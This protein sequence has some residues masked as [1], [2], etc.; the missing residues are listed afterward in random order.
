M[1]WGNWQDN[2]DLFDDLLRQVYGG[3]YMDLSLFDG[4]SPHC[5][6]DAFFDTHTNQSSFPI[7]FHELKT[8]ID[9]F[10][11]KREEYIKKRKPFVGYMQVC[12][13][14]VVTYEFKENG[15]PEYL[16]LIPEP[17]NEYNDS[18]WHFTL[19][20]KYKFVSNTTIKKIYGSGTTDGYAY[21]GRIVL[22]LDWTCR[23]LTVLGPE[24]ENEVSVIEGIELKK[25]SVPKPNNKNAY[26]MLFALLKTGIIEGKDKLPR[27]E[28]ELPPILLLPSSGGWVPF[29]LLKNLPERVE[30][31]GGEFNNCFATTIASYMWE[32][33]RQFK[34]FTGSFWDKPIFGVT[35]DAEHVMTDYTK[36]ETLEHKLL[37]YDHLND[38]RKYFDEYVHKHLKA[39]LNYIVRVNNKYLPADKPLNLTIDYFNIVVALFAKPGNS[40]YP[41]QKRY[42]INKVDPAGNLP[43]I[44]LRILTKWK[45]RD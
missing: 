23:H 16:I 27:H 44:V 35:M 21:C 13:Y 9:F 4:E 40:R 12:G 41:N 11:K 10:K 34:Y 32:W 17:K 20:N 6:M 26:G 8:K 28:E 33:Y 24:K 19:D 43:T 30:M 3:K 1:A 45:W 25:K 2:D 31:S 15:F 37:K 29:Y 5:H 7:P 18:S 36:Y 14:D 42:Y 38:L 39:R 22:K